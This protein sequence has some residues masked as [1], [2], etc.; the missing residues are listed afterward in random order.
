MKPWEP[1]DTKAPVSDIRKAVAFHSRNA[2][3]EEFEEDG[4][5]LTSS[6][7]ALVDIT[8]L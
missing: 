3:S 5:L 8:I 4:K 1:D 6:S 2:D 7:R